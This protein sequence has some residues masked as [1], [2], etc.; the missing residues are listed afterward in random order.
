M[1]MCA[2]DMEMFSIAYVNG[3]LPGI[4]FVMAAVMLARP[5]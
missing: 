4:S 2:G 3:L 5:V 1:A